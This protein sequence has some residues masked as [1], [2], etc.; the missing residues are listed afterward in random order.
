M[1]LWIKSLHVIAIIS[2][3]AGLLY[4]PRLFVYHAVQPEGSARSA[5]LEVM[6]YRLLRYIMRPAMV[7]AWGSGLWLAYD[8]GFWRSGWFHGKLVLVIAMTVV[9]EFLARE[10]RC[11]AAK[12]N[13]RSEKFFRVF[14]EVPTVL[15]I[16]IVGLVILKPWS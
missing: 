8:S 13:T 12:R 11:F 16:L 14:N 5:M 3:M 1:Y 7:V 4:L 6:E 2:W 15:M 9:H 10:Q